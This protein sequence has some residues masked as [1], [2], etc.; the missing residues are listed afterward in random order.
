MLMKT[1]D[2][3]IKGQLIGGVLRL[4]EIPQPPE[5]YYSLLFLNFFI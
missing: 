4:T 2:R 3:N 5:L 1:A